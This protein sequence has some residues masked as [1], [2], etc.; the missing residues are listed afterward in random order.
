MPFKSHHLIGLSVFSVFA[1][2][3]GVMNHLITNITIV[4]CPW[5][6]LLDAGLFIFLLSLFIGQRYY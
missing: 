6:A 2:F 3:T 5:V 4:V 1:L